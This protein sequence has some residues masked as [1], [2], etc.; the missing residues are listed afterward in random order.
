V[1]RFRANFNARTQTLNG[2]DRIKAS[3]AMRYA[4]CSVPFAH[5]LRSLR[6]RSAIRLRLNKVG[7][8]LNRTEI[9]RQEIFVRHTDAELVLYK[10]YDLQNPEGINETVLQQRLVI[11][12]AFGRGKLPHKKI[13]NPVANHFFFQT[14][15]QDCNNDR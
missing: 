13:A 6:L 1:V 2:H 10:G 12:Y 14:N 9:L 8:T 7:N 5:A 3:C 15:L 11:A 4:L